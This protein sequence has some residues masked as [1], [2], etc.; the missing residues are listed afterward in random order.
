MSGNSADLE[1][2]VLSSECGSRVTYR[3]V[4]SGDL[5]DILLIL[6]LGVTVCGCGLLLAIFDFFDVGTFFGVGTYELRSEELKYP[7]LDLSS[8]LF[9]SS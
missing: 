2:S 8:P 4:E 5:R 9:L 6:L 7:E 3:I 1:Q